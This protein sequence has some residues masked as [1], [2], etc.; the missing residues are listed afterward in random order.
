MPKSNDKHVMT[1]YECDT[2]DH[3]ILELDGERIYSGSDYSLEVVF[4]LAKHLGWTINTTSF[5]YTE[6]SDRFL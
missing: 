4:R 6:F 5:S 1:V 2:H 3:K